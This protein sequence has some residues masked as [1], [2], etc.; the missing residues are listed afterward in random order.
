MGVAVGVSAARISTSRGPVDASMKARL[1]D[2]LATEFGFWV[3]TGLFG[4]A[5]EVQLN[6]SLAGLDGGPPHDDLVAGVASRVRCRSG[7][8]SPPLNAQLPL[9]SQSNPP[10]SA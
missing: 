6:G 7:T 9:K 10:G 5:A 4:M 3:S 2:G 8:G 1:E